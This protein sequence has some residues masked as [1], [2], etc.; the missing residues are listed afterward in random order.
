[1]NIKISELND[2]KSKQKFSDEE[3]E[4]RGLNPS[5]KDLCIKL[6]IFFNNLLAKLISTCEN[7]KSEKEIKNVL[8]NYLR[9]I[10][11]DEFDTEE[12]EFIADYFEEITQILKINIGEKL[13]FLVYQIPLNNYELTKKQYSDKILEDERKR[14]EILSTECRKCKTQLETFI[15]ERDSEIP[16]FDFEIVKCV[17]CLEY[18]ILDN[19]PGIKRYRFLNYELVEELPKDEYDLEKALVRL[20]Q[21]KNMKN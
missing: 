17:K 7:K 6:E 1:M 18:N 20:E 3:W 21:I 9:E 16:D 11:S 4:K 10:D 19:G 15:L 8:E 13:N 5:E 12:R 14:H 2:L